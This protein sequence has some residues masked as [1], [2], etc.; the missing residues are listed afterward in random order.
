M[1]IR[2]KLQNK[3]H[4]IEAL[5]RAKFSFPG[6]Q[7]IH[8]SKKWRFTKFNTDEFENMVAEKR[9]IPDGCAVKYVPNCGPLDKLS[10]PALMSISA[11]PSL[12]TLTNK[13]YFLSKI[14]NKN[15][16]KYC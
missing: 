16:I 3:E 15:K 13:C 8:I 5:R 9:L 4:V 14:K 1:S 10:G 12:I 6:R 2:T 11:V 7:K